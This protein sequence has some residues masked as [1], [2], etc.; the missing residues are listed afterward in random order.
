VKKGKAKSGKRE[1]MDEEKFIVKTEI[2]EIEF[3]EKGGENNYKGC[4]ISKDR[5]NTRRGKYHFPRR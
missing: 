3:K 2:E 5:L 1:N 4:F